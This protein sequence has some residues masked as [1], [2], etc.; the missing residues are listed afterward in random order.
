MKPGVEFSLAPGEGAGLFLRAFMP[1]DYSSFSTNMVRLLDRL[2][3]WLFD[4][5]QRARDVDATMAVEGV[6]H[7]VVNTSPDEPLGLYTL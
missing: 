2:R 3:A 1:V 6:E 5:P 4:D 7:N